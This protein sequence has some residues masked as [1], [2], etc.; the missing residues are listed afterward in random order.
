VDAPNRW[1]L[2][3][4]EKGGKPRLRG[5][6]GR[7]VERRIGL[8]EA[9]EVLVKALREASGG[10]L[11]RVRIERHERWGVA[12]GG[13]FVPLQKPRVFYEVQLSLNGGRRAAK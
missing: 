7:E 10:D 1:H 12:Q 11:T 2:V 3:M 8:D 13:R 9:P 6:G 5:A 4:R